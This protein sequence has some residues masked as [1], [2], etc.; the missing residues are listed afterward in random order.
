MGNP[1]NNKCFQE[2]IFSDI[3]ISGSN[4]EV[5]GSLQESLTDNGL[6][7]TINSKGISATFNMDNDRIISFANMLG[8][9]TTKQVPSRIKGSGYLQR[10]IFWLNGRSSSTAYGSVK[11]K[12]I[13]AINNWDEYFS[14]RYGLR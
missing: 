11:G 7:T 10:S 2:P 5:M 6:C 4:K 8:K 3:V 1:S 9:N 13:A 14:V 12:I